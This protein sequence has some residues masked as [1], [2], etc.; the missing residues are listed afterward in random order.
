MLA[1]GQPRNDS[2]FKRISAYVMQDDVLYAFLTVKE[3]I[4]L[5]AQLHLPGTVS[6]EDKMR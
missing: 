3:T 4:W 1:N 5:S 2:D 6:Y